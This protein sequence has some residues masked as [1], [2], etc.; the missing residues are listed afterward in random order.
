MDQL[1]EWWLNDNEID[2]YGISTLIKYLPLFSRS[3]SFWIDGNLVSSEMQGK[4]RTAVSCVIA[5][6]N[7][8]SYGL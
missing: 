7:V 4:L 1:Q 5:K 3:C 8:I 6:V 2:D